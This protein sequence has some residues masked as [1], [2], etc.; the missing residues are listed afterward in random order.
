MKWYGSVNN[1]IDERRPSQKPEVGMGITEYMWSDRNAY[2]IT[3]VF[4]DKHFMMRRYKAV[5][6][7]CYGEDNWELV[8]DTEMPEEEVIFRYGAW[9][10]VR[11][12]TKESVDRCIKED[13]FI[14]LDQKTLDKVNTKGV[15]YKYD[16]ANIVIGHAD[17]YYDWS[18]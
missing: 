1:R 11:T 18:F 4:D 2:E 8:S 10:R 3:K 5:H 7:G 15:A 13:G 6:H 14:A 16:K 12:Y 9:Y 17:Y